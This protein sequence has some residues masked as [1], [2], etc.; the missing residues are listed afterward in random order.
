MFWRYSYLLIWQLFHQAIGDL[1]FLLGGSLFLIINAGRPH[2]SA[3]VALHRARSSI[4]LLCHLIRS[5]PQCDSQIDIVNRTSPRGLLQSQCLKGL[6]SVESILMLAMRSEECACSEVELSRVCAWFLLSTIA[7][8]AG[9]RTPLSKSRRRV[10]CIILS[11]Q[12]ISSKSGYHL[13]SSKEYRS[14]RQS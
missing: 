11:C 6:L 12:R 13:Y 8:I 10:T 3:I 2:R 7:V 4:T 14:I 1:K 9:G 5:S